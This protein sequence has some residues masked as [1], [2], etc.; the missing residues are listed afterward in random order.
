MEYKTKD[1]SGKEETKQVIVKC[2]GVTQ[3]I[4]GN[5]DFNNI[6]VSTNDANT[7]TLENSQAVAN[8]VNQIKTN[9]EKERIRISRDNTFLAAELSTM[10]DT[11]V[12]GN[13]GCLG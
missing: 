2:T 7:I 5:Y 11:D 12:N 10:C 3:N 13:T 4:D 1:A 6:A 9:N 8:A